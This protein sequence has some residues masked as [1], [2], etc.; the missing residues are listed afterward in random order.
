MTWSVQ[1]SGHPGFKDILISEKW[2]QPLLIEDEETKNNTDYA[3]NKN[4][5]ESMKVGRITFHQLKILQ[6]E[7][8]YMALLKNCSSYV[9]TF[10]TNTV[11][12]WWYIC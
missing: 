12:I 7:R 5:K 1:E 10:N 11:G 9:P 3:P 6:K 8:L 4:L 2:L